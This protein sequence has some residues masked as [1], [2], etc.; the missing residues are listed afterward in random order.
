MGQLFFQEI[1]RKINM[2]DIKTMNE[3]YE[4]C[5]KITNTYFSIKNKKIKN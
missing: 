5:K 3:Y 1:F 2:T 4:L